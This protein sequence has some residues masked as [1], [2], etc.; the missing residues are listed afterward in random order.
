SATTS[1]RTQVEVSRLRSRA[2]SSTSARSSGVIRTRSVFVLTFAGSFGLPAMISIV[3]TEKTG[4]KPTDIHCSHRDA[5][6]NAGVDGACE[7]LLMDMR[8]LKAMEIAA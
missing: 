3:A 8:E 1:N 2:A 5:T 4:S 6:L 7:G